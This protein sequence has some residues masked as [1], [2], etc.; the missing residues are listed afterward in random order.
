[1]KWLHIRLRVFICCYTNQV[2]LSLLIWYGITVGGG[3]SFHALLAWLCCH[4]A[5]LELQCSRPI[6]QTRQGKR[7]RR[8]HHLP[9]PH[10]R[11]MIILLSE[12]EYRCLPLSWLRWRDACRWSVTMVTRGK[13]SISSGHVS[14]T[15]A[16]NRGGQSV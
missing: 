11:M 15:E 6:R 3:H 14:M 13:L 1:M 8:S 12:N 4:K 9:W 16:F 2:E 5:C 7:Q 10:H